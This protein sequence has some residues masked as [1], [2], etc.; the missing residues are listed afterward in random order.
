M[1]KGV[2]G[3]VCLLGRKAPGSPRIK[4]IWVWPHFLHSSIVLF[5][6]ALEQLM[7]WGE[8]REEEN[9]VTFL[10]DPAL[11]MRTEDYEDQSKS[12]FQLFN[13]P[14]PLNMK[15]LT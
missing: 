14:C 11:A 5:S 3:G 13:G 8:G 1:R 10:S 9:T 2:L 12:K 15:A 4:C 6:S 7:I